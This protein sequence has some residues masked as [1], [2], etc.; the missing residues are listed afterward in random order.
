LPRGPCAPRRQTSRSG[1]HPVRWGRYYIN[2]HF[3]FGSEEDAN[4]LLR[5][6][7]E[8][9]ASP[10]DLPAALHEAVLRQYEQN[11]STAS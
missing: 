3:L 8:L 10:L 9:A 2:T 6:I 11:R 1:I 4:G 7:D 5:R